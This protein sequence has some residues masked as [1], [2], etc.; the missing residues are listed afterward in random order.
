MQENFKRFG[1]PIVMNI[2]HLDSNPE[3]DIVCG[4]IFKN[5]HQPIHH[6]MQMSKNWFTVYFLLE[7][8]T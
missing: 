4:A 2:P 8:C 7:A 6:V 5:Y 3:S 1:N